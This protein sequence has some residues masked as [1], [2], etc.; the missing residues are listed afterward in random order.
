VQLRGRRK[1][2]RTALA[3]AVAC[4]ALVLAGF[5]GAIDNAGLSIERVSGEGW[6]AE[7]IIVDL[8]LPRDRA[9]A[10]IARVRLSATSQELRDVRI[11]CQ[12]LELSDAAIA[13]TQ[14]QIVAG[15]TGVGPQSFA[16]K[17]TY[18]RRDGSLEVIAD[19]LDL[20]SGTANVA[21]RLR[22][23]GWSAKAHLERVPVEVV[24]KLARQLRLPVPALSAS[25]LVTLSATA[26]GTAGDLH[27]STFEVSFVELTANNE[28]GS[29]ATDKLN[30]SL[31]GN[32]RKS[33]ADWHFS[34]ELASAQGQAYVQPIFLDLGAHAL[35]AS[36]SGTFNGAGRLTLERVA[37]DHAKVANASGSALVEFANEQPLRSLAL[38]LAS[39]EFPGAYESYLQ[40]LLLDTNFKAMQTAGKLSGAVTIED[41]VPRS[42]DLTLDDIAFD[43]GKRKFALDALRGQLHWRSESDAK[44][45]D[46]AARIALGN[47]ARSS[48][49]WRGGA[50]LGLSV[51]AADLQFAVGG[52]EFRL[53][54][55]ARIPLLDGAL[56]LESFRVRNAGLPSV[57][58]MVDA[59]LEPIDV[60][61]LC[62]AFGWPQ[63]GGQI[64]GK[65][66]KLRM[67]DGV[68]TLG[69]TLH[70]QVFD[71][72]VTVSDLRLQQPFG[73]WPR[74]YS[75]VALE[76]LDLELVTGA[77]SFGRMTGR[78]S[79]RIDEL[80]LFN[81]APVAFDARLYTPADDRSQHRISQRAVE[82]IGSIGGGGAGVTAALSS[83]FLRFFDDFNYER[84][85]LSCRLENDVCAMSGVAAAPNGGYYLVKGRGLPR[86]DVIGSSTRVD[87]PRLV[88]QLIAA[89]QSGGP[90]VE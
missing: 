40:P 89:T 42:L 55:P 3:L 6:S 72:E 22:S 68:M 66:S 11:D 19:G 33:A 81:W 45:D 23:G 7:D 16:A 39:V 71:G 14:A 73:K 21:G 48:L 34:I 46:D 53:L 9:L 41:G 85:G 61:Q 63:F 54:Q 8:E 35:N 69:T 79:G 83:G 37:L 50:I 74:F 17:V 20:G 1:H 13:C 47:A 49:N 60:K 29:L 62:Q 4:A 28:S 58:F 88:Q 5:V 57:A 36:A 82:N 12:H 18:G 25:G 90:T 77:F 31:R 38:Q 87:W 10:T 67:R 27:A 64:G 32:V 51:G 15:W 44:G 56:S 30:A 59:A 84:L 26:N 86:I 52:R 70:A 76:N 78:L 43:D 75:N 24:D 80:R 65:I 2:L